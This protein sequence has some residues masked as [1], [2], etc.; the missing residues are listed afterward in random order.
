[1]IPTYYGLKSSSS[2]LITDGD[3]SSDTW[4]TKEQTGVT[5]SGGECILN[6]AIT[7]GPQLTSGTIGINVGSTYKVEF[8][9]T[10]YTSGKLRWCFGDINTPVYA[11]GIDHT[12]NGHYIENGFVGAGGLA[13]ITFFSESPGPVMHLDNVSVKLV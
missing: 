12:A 11:N 5:I 10:S 9:I 3:F 7:Y 2:E 6:D 4:W 13:I 1:M 8:D